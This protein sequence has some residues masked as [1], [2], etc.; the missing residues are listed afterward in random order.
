[1]TPTEKQLRWGITMECCAEAMHVSLLLHK[2]HAPA[3]L[4]LTGP[5]S[6]PGGDFWRNRGSDKSAPSSHTTHVEIIL[7]RLISLSL[8]HKLGAPGALTYLS[9]KMKHLLRTCQTCRVGQIAMS[10]QQ[11][12][13]KDRRP[14]FYLLS[15]SPA[16]ERT[17]L[18]YMR[19]SLALSMASVIIAQL[20]RL[21]HAQ[22]P[23]KTFGYFTL[24]I[25]LACVC[26]GAAFIVILLG[27]YRFWRQQ[28]AIL[29]GKVH[30]G[31]WE[32]NAIGLTITLVWLPLS[33]ST[34]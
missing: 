16:L 15:P 34:R 29:R 14:I 32:I 3:M 13:C 10:F 6:R 25:P 31:G 19:T 8:S 11:A 21:E 28:N 33:S 1:M 17:F 23:N 4:Q 22:N 2:G 27:A 7:V 30:A 9:P 5:T 26:I 24:S 20:F 18:G 12:L